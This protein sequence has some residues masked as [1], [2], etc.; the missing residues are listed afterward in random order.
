MLPNE[1]FGISDVK[2]VLVRL[3]LNCTSMSSVSLKYTLD[4]RGTTTLDP[5][6]RIRDENTHRTLVNVEVLSRL[7]MIGQTQKALTTNSN[8]LREVIWRC[9]QL[10]LTIF[11][12]YVECFYS[13]RVLKIGECGDGVVS[14]PRGVGNYSCSPRQDEGQE[15][16]Q[17]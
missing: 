7:V 11:Q 4:G 5:R 15:R 8:V 6:Q 2:R 10:E 9:L 1:H 13:R 12:R 14:C 16:R 17:G 3:F